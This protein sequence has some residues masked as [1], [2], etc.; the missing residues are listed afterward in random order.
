LGITS[1]L[2][3]GTFNPFA[4]TNFLN[5]TSASSIQITNFN[6]GVTNFGASGAGVHTATA[7]SATIINDGG[8]AFFY[9]QTTAGTASITNRFGGFTGFAEQSTAGSATIVNEN[10]GSTN[11]G[12]PFSLTDAP[13]AGNATIVNHATGLT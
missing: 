2:N 7:G 9:S 6:G 8:A 5:N 4:E 10:F 12:Q 11:F 3:D 1:I 13:T